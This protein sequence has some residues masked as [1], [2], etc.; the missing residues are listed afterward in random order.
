MGRG[1]RTG[2]DAPTA[3]LLEALGGSAEEHPPAVGKEARA[4]QLCLGRAEAQPCGR[5]WGRERGE[6]EGE[7]EG[8]P[9]EGE[10]EHREGR[11]RE[12]AAVRAN[13]SW[14]ELGRVGGKK[15]AMAGE[16]GMRVE[17]TD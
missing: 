10:G 1:V 9:G 16:N 3:T 12:A 11:A 6:R 13:A 8:S 17:K 2:L 4:W 14:G 7:R 15:R 5:Q